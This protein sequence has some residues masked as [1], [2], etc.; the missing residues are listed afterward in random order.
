M[1]QKQQEIKRKN[2]NNTHSFVFMNREDRQMKYKSFKKMILK[3]CMLAILLGMLMTPLTAKTINVSDIKSQSA[4]IDII[5][6]GTILYVGGNGPNNYTSIQEAIDDANDG[7]TVFVYSNT[8]Q[9]SLVIN[10]TIALLGESKETTIIDGNDSYCVI[11]LNAEDVLIDGFTITTNLQ[12]Y[13]A[14][15]IEINGNN[16][17]ITNNIITDLGRGVDIYRSTNNRIG[18][19][20]FENSGIILPTS[21]I[22]QNFVQDN[23]VNNQPLVYYIDVVDMII[24]NPSG[25]IILIDCTN[26]TIKNQDLKYTPI[27]LQLNGCIGCKIVNNNIYSCYNE[28]I[29]L[30]YSDDC[31]I[32]HNDIQ[33]CADVG[34]YFITTD[35]CTLDHNNIFLNR[36]A[37]ASEYSTLNTYTNNNFGNN[38]LCVL[39]IIGTLNKWDHNYWNRGRLF[40]KLIFEFPRISMDRNPAKERN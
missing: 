22:Y 36:I 21:S 10:T 39:S 8:Y 33:A 40:P 14:T 19:N 20:I 27:A 2:L 18:S 1:K 32:Q 4:Q 15:A 26:I 29:R 11:E 25:Q 6:K 16:S 38:G 34:I 5:F 17:I 31:I 35:N 30:A 28:G 3:I 37:F 13:Y 23:L 24:D 9:E 7:D 12:S